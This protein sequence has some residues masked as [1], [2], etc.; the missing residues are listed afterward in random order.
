VIDRLE[1]KG[2]VERE[3]SDRDRR[4]RRL[5]LTPGGERLLAASRT[6]VEALQADILAPLSASERAVFLAL[7]HLALGLG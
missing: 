2:L 5:H 4:A 3:V 7:A 1:T 6:V